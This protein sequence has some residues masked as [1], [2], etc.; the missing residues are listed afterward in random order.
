MAKKKVT[1]KEPASYFNA[2]MRRVAENWDKEHPDKENTETAKG[3]KPDTVK[4]SGNKTTK[5]KK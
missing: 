3:K 1:Y 2:D 5:A 4:R